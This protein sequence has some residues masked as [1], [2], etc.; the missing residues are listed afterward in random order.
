MTRAHAARELLNLGPLSFREFCEITRWPSRQ[1]SKVLDYLQDRGEV[2]RD[3][4][5][6]LA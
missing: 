3:P 5:W 1:C 6:R 2:V 4:L